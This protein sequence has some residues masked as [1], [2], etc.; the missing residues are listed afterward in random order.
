MS[1]RK[2]VTV[3]RFDGPRFKDHGLDVDVLPEIIAYKVLLQETAKE[4]WRLKHPD[5]VRLPKNFYAEINLKF[6][7]LEAGSTAVPL[8]REWRSGQ[9]PLDDELDEAATLLQQSIHAAGQLEGAPIRLPRN[10][11]PFFYELGKTLRSD[12]C[13]LVSSDTRP[14]GARYDQLVRER[15]LAWGTSSYADAVDLTGEV[16]ATDL[17]GLKFTL[18]LLDGR[19]VTG[20]F[21]PDH[22][23]VILEALGEHFSRRIHVRGTG[24]FAPEDGTLKQIVNVEW[25][26]V[27]GSELLPEDRG[28]PIWERLALIGAD[29]PNK[30][31]NDVPTDLSEN[32]DRYLYGRKDPH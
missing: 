7:S 16:R 26:E 17:D 4:I 2:R 13:L 11:I 32:V 31:W 28:T 22:E 8:M 3:L 25:I 15:I 1:A 10:V 23:P 24:Q 19:K 29:T 18:R 14:E 5:R 30:A 6:F 21:R 20:H 12:E 9:L 27:V